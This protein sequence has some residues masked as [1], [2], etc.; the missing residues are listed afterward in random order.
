LAPEP[1]DPAL[2][3]MQVA[4]A[5]QNMFV[6]GYDSGEAFSLLCTLGSFFNHSC[7]ANCH[8]VTGSDASGRGF[9][10]IFAIR[11]VKAGEELTI[12]YANVA[13]NSFSARTVALTSR[14]M[15]CW[16]SFCAAARAGGKDPVA[17]VTATFGD[18]PLSGCLW[19]SEEAQPGAWSCCAACAQRCRTDLKDFVEP[20]SLTP[21]RFAEFTRVFQRAVSPRWTKVDAAQD[22]QFIQRD[23]DAVAEW[24][25]ARVARV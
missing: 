9:L 21:A 25:A 5:Q 2:L 22:A 13:F 23:R 15:A 14:A 19:W 6:G 16:C 18:L 3:S 8:Y 10:R 12:P 7:A 4:K 20:A 1:A 24:L 11:D 17:S